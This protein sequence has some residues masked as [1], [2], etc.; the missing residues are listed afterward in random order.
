[1]CFYVQKSRHSESKI[2]K[3]HH[4]AIIS[5]YR[6]YVQLRSWEYGQLKYQNII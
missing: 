4:R 1:M 6:H 2:P 3:N 5:R